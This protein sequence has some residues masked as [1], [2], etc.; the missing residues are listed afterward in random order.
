MEQ[1]Y[2]ELQLS[3]DTTPSGVYYT[4]GRHTPTRRQHKRELLLTFITHTNTPKRKRKT[5]PVKPTL[6]HSLLSLLLA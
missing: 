3:S 5:A 6:L 1:N 2:S 4:P